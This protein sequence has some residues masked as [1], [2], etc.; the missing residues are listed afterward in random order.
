[1]QA[2]RDEALAYHLADSL[3][4]PGALPLFKVYAKRYPPYFLRDT[5]A[6]VLSMPQEKIRTN[7]AALFVHL[8]Q[9]YDPK[10]HARP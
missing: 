8:V 7:R 10:Y 2:L 3:D 9:Q 1:M 5:L 6:K 4:D